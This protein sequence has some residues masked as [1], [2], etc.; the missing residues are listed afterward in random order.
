M[1]F[2]TLLATAIIT[3]TIIQAQEQQQQQQ[4]WQP[5]TISHDQMKLFPQP[6]PVTISE[7]ASIKFTPQLDGC[8]P[9]LALNEAGETSGGLKTF[10]SRM[11]GTRLNLRAVNV[12]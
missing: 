5:T 11:Q 1:M 4:Q 9:Y 10:G 3:R 6:D 12:A 8:H 7:K 2:S